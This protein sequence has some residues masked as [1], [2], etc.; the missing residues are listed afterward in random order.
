MSH[1]VDFDAINRVALNRFEALLGQFLPDGKRVNGEYVARNPRR[2][3][4]NIGSF[5]IN[6]NTGVWKDFADDSGGGD[7]VSLWAYLF[8]LPSQ[9]DAARLL[10]G[11]LGVP[12]L[13]P[14]YVKSTNTATN[15]DAGEWVPIMP[16]PDDAPAPPDV[17]WYKD[18]EQWI[19]RKIVARWAYRDASGALLGY[20]ARVELP[21]GGKDVVPQ[22]FCQNESGERKWRVKSFPKPR[23]LYG[24][25]RLAARPD[26]PVVIFEGEKTADAGSALIDRCV[27]VAWAGGAEA[28]A[29]VDLEPLRGRS[30][31]LWPDN[32]AAGFKAMMSM[33]ARLGGIAA[34]I[35]IVRPPEWADAGWDVADDAPEDWSAVAH[36]RGASVVPSE[37]FKQNDDDSCGAPSA[38]EFERLGDLTC[39][40]M[41]QH[42]I[43]IQGRHESS[44]VWLRLASRN[45]PAHIT[46]Q[47]LSRKAE[48]LSIMPKSAWE[49]FIMRSGEGDRFTV[50]NAVSA[51]VK[52]ADE[53]GIW[54]P[55]Q[56]EATTDVDAPANALTGVQAR[57][58]MILSTKLQNL[59][60]FDEGS[61]CWYQ[62]Q[63]IWRKVSEEAIRQFVIGEADKWLAQEYE[64][65]YVNGTVA[66]MKTRLVRLSVTEDRADGDIWEDDRNLLPMRNGVL[67]LTAKQIIPHSPDMMFNWM[68]PHCYDP[69]ATCPVTQRFIHR[70][71][72]GDA[73]TEAVLYA[74]LAAVL[75]GRYD[76][77]RYLEFVGMAGTGKSTYISLCKELVGAQNVHSTDMKTLHNNQFETAN[78]YSKRLVMISDA[79]KYGG[80][81]GI[82]KSMTGRDVIRREEKNRQAQ[83]G[84]VYKGM[85]IVAANNPIQFADT[86]TA[87]V[88]RRVPVHIDKK[89]DKAEV[90]YKLAESMAREI[91]GLINLLLELS[92]DDVTAVLSDYGNHRKHAA[93]R[94]LVDTNAVAAWANENLIVSNGAS[95]QVGKLDMNA[96]Q[97]LY[98]NFSQFCEQTGRRGVVSF[99]TFTR[100]LQDVLA[101]AGIDVDTKKRNTGTHIVGVRL[102]TKSSLDDNIPPLLAR[103]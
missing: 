61:Q 28:I 102:R 91:P 41:T 93:M 36:L 83:S 60:L 70:L 44:G 54:M 80:D 98:P 87:M 69:E 76:L 62:W 3:D 96:D 74:F 63:S 34:K 42:K 64:N 33:A 1:S 81:I 65:A 86:S 78:I 92:Q 77:E 82:F 43:H 73:S 12:E 103:H 32:D 49:E 45:D 99:N 52:A 97:Y 11:H 21:D 72:G 17:K 38:P 101:T 71:A 48:L 39:W 47:R 95:V 29:Y 13:A 19:K 6:L 89:L 24:L 66:L 59:T 18:G 14:D 2:N 37:F 16:V 27:S 20:V 88:R 7:P 57:D 58:S 84:F 30:V 56:K 4:R 5:S 10:A 23:P 90:D 22:T 53:N 85:V 26:A 75:H 46:M 94:A 51:I 40:L 35:V 25:D 55:P 15:Q 68:V 8:G 100:S 9:S 67:D 50:D 31:A 79:D